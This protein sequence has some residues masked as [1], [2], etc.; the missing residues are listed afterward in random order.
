MVAITDYGKDSDQRQAVAAGFDP[1][2]VKS[3]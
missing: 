2:L 3:Q 1:Y